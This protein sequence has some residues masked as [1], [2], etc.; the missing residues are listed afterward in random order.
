MQLTVCRSQRAP[1][2]FAP[3]EC[4]P[5]LSLQFH[6]RHDFAEYPCYSVYLELVITDSNLN[7]FFRLP[8][9]VKVQHFHRPFFLLGTSFKARSFSIPTSNIRFQGE[10]RN[11][12]KR[13][14]TNTSEP[15]TVA[16]ITMH[17]H[18]TRRDHETGYRNKI[19]LVVRSGR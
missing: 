17:E 2:I 13:A 14:R 8:C 1:I 9:A 11:R 6:E 15:A 12:C 18:A 10:I 4:D 5:A 7:L 3:Y 19:L 16:S